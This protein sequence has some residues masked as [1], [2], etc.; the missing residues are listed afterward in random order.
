[1]LFVPK[2][3]GFL[4]LPAFWSLFEGRG[5][6]AEGLCPVRQQDSLMV[7]IFALKNL[8]FIS[9]PSKAGEYKSAY[10]KLSMYVFKKNL[11]PF[12]CH[13]MKEMGKQG[14]YREKK[15]AKISWSKYF[16]EQQSTV[17]ISTV[18][19]S[20]SEQKP[21]LEWGDLRASLKPSISASPL[22]NSAGEQRS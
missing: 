12:F 17:V 11:L 9:S 4:S 16:K 21:G 22:I 7:Y 6:F 5:S 1:M 19:M 15:N 18:C 2:Q 8:K 14:Y 10:R 20:S 13:I 3:H